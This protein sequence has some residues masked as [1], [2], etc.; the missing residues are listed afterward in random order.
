MLRPG[1]KYCK[2]IRPAACAR[3]GAAMLTTCARRKYIHHPNLCQ[4]VDAMCAQA[5][6]LCVVSE[7]YDVTLGELLLHNYSSGLPE[8]GVWA[9]AAQLLAG[10]AALHERGITHQRLA[11]DNVLVCNTDRRGIPT[12][13]L[14]DYGLSHISCGGGLS[15]CY[16]SRP[17]YLSPERVA[18]GP[19]AVTNTKDAQLWDVWST[20][21][22]LLETIEGSL[23]YPLAQ[24]TNGEVLRGILEI[25]RQRIV[26]TSTLESGAAA[27]PAS[28]PGR[29]ASVAVPLQQLLNDCLELAGQ[30]C[31]AAELLSQHPI[32]SH[33]S[34]GGDGPA[35]SAVAATIARTSLT[36]GEGEL[37]CTSLPPIAATP[38]PPPVPLFRGRHND[39]AAVR[40][41][42]QEQT[43]QSVEEKG[44]FTASEQ[45]RTTAL[46]RLKTE[47]FEWQAR[48]PPIDGAG[49]EGGEGSPHI[50]FT[51]RTATEV[52]AL[53][54][55]A[56]R[57]PGGGSTP[58]AIFWPIHGAPP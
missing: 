17:S 6:R 46:R 53:L 4:Y 31:T 27:W 40:A 29:F 1:F 12:L 8:P 2:R 21:I 15:P 43:G 23:P 55:S 37:R 7:H 50:S 33:T 42:E 52:E 36:R 9:A 13:K 5:L 57:G 16:P 32:L 49:G 24:P 20:G 26:A 10:V 34:V 38:T 48:V 35:A 51:P 19:T 56:V 14:S 47:F 28:E 44:T 25:A 41:G 11:S 30:R 3:Y 18:A 22:L 58:A 39:D 54:R 45:V